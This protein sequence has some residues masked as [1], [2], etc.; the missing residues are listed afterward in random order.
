VYLVSTGNLVY[1]PVV[2]TTISN[3]TCLP[4]LFQHNYARNDD[5][6]LDLIFS[7]VTDFSIN[8]DVH[9]LVHP[10]VYHPPFVTELTLPSRRSNML[11]NISSR[12]YSSGDY[13]MIYNTLST[14]DWSSV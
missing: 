12:K 9:S 3:A 7:N 4:G 14:Y 11:P 13:L 5:N 6:L 2:L 10:D 1:L 8:Y